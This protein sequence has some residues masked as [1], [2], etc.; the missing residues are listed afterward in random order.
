MA[1]KAK[2]GRPKN[3]VRFQLS[4]KEEAFCWNYI[5]GGMS[6]SDAVIEA[7]YTC[8]SRPNKYKEARRILEREIIKKRI[9]ELLEQRDR[10]FLLDKKFVVDGLKRIAIEQK[11]KPG[12]IRAFELLGRSIGA[13]DDKQV[14]EI[15]A[16]HAKLADDAWA[17]RKKHIAKH[18]PKE[19]KLLG[20][21]NEDGSLKEA[22]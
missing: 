11:G 13:F 9:T 14:Q 3:G 6:P 16:G 19:A 22:G 8:T 5:M 12:E 7:G 10:E 18:E 15:G 4:D 17:I 21:V 1:G 2:T 20:I